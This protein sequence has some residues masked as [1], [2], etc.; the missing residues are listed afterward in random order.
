MAT[1][2]VR[3]GIGIP[4]MGNLKTISCVKYGR[5]IPQQKSKLFV[6]DMWPTVSFKFVTMSA[7]FTPLFSRSRRS[8]AG[9]MWGIHR[10]KNSRTFFILWFWRQPGEKLLLKKTTGKS[11]S[12]TPNS[13]LGQWMS[14]YF[15]PHSG[16]SLNFLGI[17][18]SAF[19]C[20]PVMYYSSGE[21]VIFFLGRRKWSTHPAWTPKRLTLF[22]IT[23]RT[24]EVQR[25]LDKLELAAQ[26]TAVI[27]WSS[28]STGSI[29]F[30]LQ[31]L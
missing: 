26:P 30:L 15:S 25:G 10:G 9:K 8:I 14:S 3:D 23:V 17:Y 24:S 5:E 2:D 11:C 28:R 13:P 29:I 4:R 18:L 27:S 21:V 19:G 16:C 31:K 12:K 20:D 1:R 22:T 7:F 6:T